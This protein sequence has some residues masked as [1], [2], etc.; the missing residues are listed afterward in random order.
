MY[1]IQVEKRVMKVMIKT[2]K[3]IREKYLKFYSHLQEFW[4]QNC[5][6]PIDTIKWKLKNEKVMEVKLDKD[7][8]IFFR[9]EWKIIYILLEA[10]THNKLWTW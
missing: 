2:S 3:K 7:F 6:F 1:E 4:T 9:K 8:R 10:W 5:P